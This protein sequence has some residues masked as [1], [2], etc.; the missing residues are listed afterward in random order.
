MLVTIVIIPFYLTK[1]KARVRRN[2]LKHDMTART[3]MPALPQEDPR[4]LQERIEQSTGDLQSRHTLQLD[5]VLQPA[6]LSPAA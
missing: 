5:L 3:A 6:Q 1:G 2:A 4:L